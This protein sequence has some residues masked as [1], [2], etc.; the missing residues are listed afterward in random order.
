MK[1]CAVDSRRPRGFTLIEL[2]VVIA[3]IAILAAMLLPA[4]TKAKVQAQGIQCMNNGNQLAKAWTI[5]AGDNGDACVN[6]FGESEYEESKGFYRTWSVDQMDYSTGSDNTN[7][8]LLQRG[9]LGPYLGK[10]VG[11]FK[12]PADHYLAS[13]Q[14]QAGFLARV[15]SMSL[16]CFLGLFSPCSTCSGGPPGS[17]DDPTWQGQNW[18]DESWPQYLKI[19][20]V[21]RPSQIYLFLDEH[22]DSINDGYFDDNIQTDPTNPND[23]PTWVGS[24]VPAWYHNGACGFSFTD[25]HSELHK[26]L[27]PAT[28]LPIKLALLN[29]GAPASMDANGPVDRNW[30]CSHACIPVPGTS[31]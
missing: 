15:R 6:N 26:W 16:N 11:C 3:I 4:L 12:C 7:A 28:L 10:S 18:A 31:E 13:L 17:G 27:L 29:A 25:A 14:V 8:F 1:T 9:L 23:T 21:P 20:S 24:D 2:L 5:Y 19:A 30:L 22:P